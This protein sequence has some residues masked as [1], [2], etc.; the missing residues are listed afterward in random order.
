MFERRVKQLRR[1][2]EIDNSLMHVWG[3][4]GSGKTLFAIMEAASASKN[5]R[6]EWLN[7]D[8]KTG[9]ISVLKANTKAQGGN[10]SNIAVTLASG[11]KDALKAIQRIVVNLHDDTKLIVIDTL[12]RVLDMTRNDEILWGRDLLEE[13]LP[14]LVAQTERG[15]RVLIISEVRYLDVAVLP[16]MYNA[17]ARWNPANLHMTRGP[18]RHSTISVPDAHDENPIALLKIDEDGVVYISSLCESQNLTGGERNCLGSQS[19]A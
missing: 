12:T 7:T 19:F 3:P 9:F 1:N 2:L 15:I 16:V 17:I 11:H 14:L 6:V 8:G 5:G 4:A 13:A 10:S 18:G